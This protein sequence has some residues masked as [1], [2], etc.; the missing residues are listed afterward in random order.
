MEEWVDREE[1][2]R[3]QVASEVPEER[4]A[5]LLVLLSAWPRSALAIYRSYLI[6]V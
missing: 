6:P 2:E 3:Q 1:L 5:A 4:E